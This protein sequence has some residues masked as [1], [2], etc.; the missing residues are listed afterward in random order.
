MAA[1]RIALAQLH[2]CP[3]A[4][5]L[6][7]RTVGNPAHVGRLAERTISIVQPLPGNFEPAP[8]SLGG[9]HQI[10][11]AAELVGMRSLT[12]LVP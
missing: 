10:D 11:R 12:T 8:H 1:L 5:C 2:R 7:S 6:P 3:L 4:A 9:K